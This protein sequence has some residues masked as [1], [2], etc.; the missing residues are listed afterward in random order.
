[1]ARQKH[2]AWMQEQM[3]QTRFKSAVDVAELGQGF[4]HGFVVHD[5]LEMDRFRQNRMLRSERNDRT[6]HDA[7]PTFW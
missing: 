3:P 7:L 2:R 5:K 4:D 6:G 1:M